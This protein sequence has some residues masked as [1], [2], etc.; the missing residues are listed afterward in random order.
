MRQLKYCALSL[1]NTED[2]ASRLFPQLSALPIEAYQHGVL[3]D[4]GC[5]YGRW[6]RYF[7]DRD[8]RVIGVDLSTDSIELCAQEY[9][10]RKAVG[11]VQA[12]LAHLP[13]PQ[14][15]FDHVWSFGVLHHTPD[16]QAALTQLVQHLRPGGH[17]SVWVYGENPMLD[18][19]RGLLNRLPPRLLYALLAVHNYGVVSWMRHL[20]PL[21]TLYNRFVPMSDYPEAWHRLHT[22]FDAYAPT[23]A[24]RT[25]YPTVYQWCQQLSLTDIRLTPAQ[26]AITAT[27][28][29]R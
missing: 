18:A 12:D 17:V 20:G 10:S 27:K 16:T 21:H 24:H 11:L 26:I 25:T 1:P 7:S 8:V 3:L 5:G 28:P 23:Y 22:D 14:D 6:V 2:S 4:A 9:G 19:W 13:F 15:H 29:L